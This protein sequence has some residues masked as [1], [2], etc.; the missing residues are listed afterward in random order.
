[1]IMNKIN[2]FNNLEHIQNSYNDE[3]LWEHAFDELA[4]NAYEDAVDGVEEAKPYLEP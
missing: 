4:S 3:T 2:N 1:M